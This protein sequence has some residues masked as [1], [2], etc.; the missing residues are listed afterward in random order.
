MLYVTIIVL[1][2]ADVRCAVVNTR[3]IANWMM[4]CMMREGDHCIV[5]RYNTGVS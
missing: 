3:K 2:V 5:V 1:T 4:S